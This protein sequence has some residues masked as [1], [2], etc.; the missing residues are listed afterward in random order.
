MS[1]HQSRAYLIAYDIADP[2]RLAR[3]HRCLKR[4]AVPVQYSVFLTRT[5]PSQ[6]QRIKDAV[7]TEIDEREDDVRFYLVPDRTEVTVFGRK[8]LPEGVLL[9]A[10]D[11]DRFFAALTAQREGDSVKDAEHA[12]E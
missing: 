1:N 12:A 8:P 11:E 4:E 6:L 7:A 9:L 10:E 2:R 5:T 3:V